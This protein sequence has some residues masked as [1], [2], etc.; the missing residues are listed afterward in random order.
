MK[1]CYDTRL[2]SSLGFQ[3][4]LRHT[5]FIMSAERIQIYVK[6]AGSSEVNPVV[7]FRG[8]SSDSIRASI[9]A[10]LDTPKGSTIIVRESEG[11]SQ[12]YKLIMNDICER[13]R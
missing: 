4:S 2:V 7:F 6:L 9:S 11:R 1:L 8:S 3:W 13:C 12:Y 5:L 10:A